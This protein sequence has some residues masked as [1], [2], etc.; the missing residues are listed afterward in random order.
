VSSSRRLAPWVIALLATYAYFVGAP[1]WNQNSRFALT[2]AIVAGHTFAIDP[3]HATTG[4]KSW[5]DGHYY[6][7][8]APGA[9]WLATP[10]YALFHAARRVT[11]G[12]LPDVAVRSLDP[13]DRVL[14]RAPDPADLEPGDRLHYNNAYRLG[15]YLCTLL[16][17]GLLCA[18]AA[19]AVYRIARRDLRADEALAR[20]VAVTQALAT[21]ALAYATSFYGHATCGAALVIAY[22]LLTMPRPQRRHALAMGALAGLAVAT[23]Y[24]AAAV[25]AVLW[26]LGAWWHGRAFAGWSALTAAGWA[27]ALAGYH[28]IAFGHPLATGYDFLVTPQFAE[29]MRVNYGIAAPD[30]ATG[31]QLL[32]GTY[33]G[34]FYLSPVLLVAAWGLWCDVVSTD[35]RARRHATVA[36][37]VALYYWLLNAGYFMWD[38]GSAAGPRHMVPMLG[39]FGLGLVT[40]WRRAP[41][42]TTVLAAVSTV[43]MLMIASVGPEAPRS[44]N[45]LW[46]YAWGHL[47]AADQGQG[48]TNLGRLLGLPGLTSLLPLA[49]VWWWARQ[50]APHR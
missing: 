37:V 15:L 32:F 26:G 1:A 25:A 24:P 14:A 43:Q 6:C 17:T 7:D 42:I 31:L 16:S 48:A 27:L 20:R 38:G 21:P 44:G 49:A 11:G 22:W 12:E 29:G 34:L 2:R 8:K 36:L 50:A 45:P 4:D 39:F 46:E 28:Q 9:S 10:A 40:A 41:Q 47:W 35:A 19:W 5:R 13:R 33:R 30:P 18:L 23:E 3:Y